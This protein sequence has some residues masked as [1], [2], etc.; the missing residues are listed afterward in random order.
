MAAP[1]ELER[2]I[3]KNV[4]VI[5]IDGGGCG[6]ALNRRSEYPKDVG[7]NSLSNASHVEPLDTPVLQSMGLRN[8]PGLENVI[9]SQTKGT[10]KVR[11]AFGA[12]TP[13][14]KGN[15]SP[16]GHQALMGHIVKESFRVFD[17][18]GFPLE[19]VDLVED[20]IATVMK[21]PVE[22]VRYPGTDDVN[23]VKF[24]NQEGIGDAHLASGKGE[25]PLIVPIYASS[26]SL[27]QIALHRAVVPQDQIEKI[28]KAVREAVDREN[29]RIA[30]IIMRPFVGGPTPGTFTRVSSDRRDYGVDPDGPTLIDHLSEAGVIVHGLGK[31]ASMLNYHGFDPKN[32]QKL[33]TDEERLS[34]IISSTADYNNDSNTHFSLDN[35]VG[36]DELYGHPR[37]PVEYS[38]HIA[39]I[40]SQLAKGMN[41]MSDKDLWI[42]TADHGNDPTQTLHNNHTNENTPILVYSR[43]MQQPIDLGVR[44]SFADVA[45]TIAENYG[46]ADKIPNGISFLKELVEN[47]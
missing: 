26:D 17:E 4:R 11:G 28:G 24:I 22:V 12:L 44:F 6:E 2:P 7:V 27:I 14:F 23:G 15:G 9:T 3:F 40:D 41:E 18:T 37:K 43:T 42:I 35:L 8:V 19:I 31:A 5:I 38:R 33:A 1:Q 21:R 16:E 34:A 20:T 32:I 46:I 25:G 29:L 13:T 10:V 47:K 39:M 36:T 45:K 30:R